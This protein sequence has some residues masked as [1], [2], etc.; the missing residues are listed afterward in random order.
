M[1][2]IRAKLIAAYADVRARPDDIE[3]AS[4]PIDEEGLARGVASANAGK[5][6]D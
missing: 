4:E 6:K 2:G 1:L 3:Q 5:A